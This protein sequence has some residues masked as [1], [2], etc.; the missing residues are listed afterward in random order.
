M[1]KSLVSE[2]QEEI[3]EWARSKEAGR[4]VDK[5]GASRCRN[6]GEEAEE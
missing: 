1:I 3:E 6:H 5:N 4:M 2:R